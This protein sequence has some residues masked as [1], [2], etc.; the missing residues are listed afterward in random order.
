MLCTPPAAAQ[1]DLTLRDLRLRLLRVDE[2]TPGNTRDDTATVMVRTATMST[3]LT[4]QEYTSSFID[5]YEIYVMYVLPTEN[6]PGHG[7]ARITVTRLPG[8]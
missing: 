7:S 6:R 5:E 8:L 2:N 3:E 4:I 1:T